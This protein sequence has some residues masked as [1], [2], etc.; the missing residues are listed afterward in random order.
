MGTLPNTTKAEIKIQA[1]IF[2]YHHNNF[3]NER[4]LLCYNLNNSANKIQ[5]NQNKSLGLIKGRSDMVYYKNGKA[6][7]IEIKT[8]TGRQSQAQKEWETI[9]K[10]A[11]FDYIIL[12]SLQDFKDFLNER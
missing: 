7:M 1:S 6:T 11:G 12:R 3:P 8:E 10:D 5:G 4:G 9:I 2:L